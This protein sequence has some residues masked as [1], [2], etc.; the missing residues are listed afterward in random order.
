MEDCG[1][2]GIKGGEDF[3]VEVFKEF[4]ISFIE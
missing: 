3:T 2:N 1:C 4:M